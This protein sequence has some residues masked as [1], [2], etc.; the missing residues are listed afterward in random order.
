MEEIWKSIE[1]YENYNVSNLGNIINII[2]GKILKQHDNG[3]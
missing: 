3:K 1:G 2:T